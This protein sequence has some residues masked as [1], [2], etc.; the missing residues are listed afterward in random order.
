MVIAITKPQN[1]D[2]H[3]TTLTVH[4]FSPFQ[5]LKRLAVAKIWEDIMTSASVDAFIIRAL[6]LTTTVIAN[7][8]N[9]GTQ[10]FRE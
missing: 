6:A 9:T 4:V 2:V 10:I 3:P 7:A 8:T 1:A 5:A